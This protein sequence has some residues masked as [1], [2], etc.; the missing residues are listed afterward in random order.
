MKKTAAVFIL[1]WGQKNSNVA[2]V[3]QGKFTEF[4]R[5]TGEKSEDLR[6]FVIFAVVYFYIGMYGALEED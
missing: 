6:F 5:E 1:L 3:L 2:I 4:I